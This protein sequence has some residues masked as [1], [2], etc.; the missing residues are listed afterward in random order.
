MNSRDTIKL[1]TIALCVGTAFHANAALYNVFEKQSPEGNDDKTY[2]VAISKSPAESQSCW[3]SACD[4][5]S[6]YFGLEVKRHE[7]GFSYRSEVPFDIGN[8]FDY[9]ADGHNGFEDYCEDYLGYTDGNCNDFFA[10]QQYDK[11][12][13]NEVDG[14]Y[15]NSIAYLFKEDGSNE[16]VPNEQPLNAVINQIS[17]DGK[18]TGSQRTETTR[19]VGFSS[20]IFLPTGDDERTQAFA[21]LVHGDKTYISGSISYKKNY[22]YWYSKATFWQLDSKGEVIDLV[23]SFDWNGGK[24]LDD[25][26]TSNGSIRDLVAIGDAVYGVGYNSND[27]EEPVATVFSNLQKGKE[28]ISIPLP[29]QK[30]YQNSIL[31]TVNENGLAVGTAKYRPKNGGSGFGRAYPNRLFY[32]EKING[33]ALNYHYVKD[34]DERVLFDGANTK[35]GAINNF[36]ELVGAVDFEKHAEIDGKPRAQRAFITTLLPSE[37]GRYENI[38]RSKSWFLDDLTN[39]SNSETENNQYRVINATDINDQGIISAT[40]MKCEGGYQSTAHDSL[41]DKTEQIVAVQ[42]VPIKGASQTDITERTIEDNY[43]ERKG[44]GLGWLALT[45]LCL[46]GFRRK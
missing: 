13:K 21:R 18:V 8:G 5:N 35:V 36:N 33:S 40:A 23:H 15:N 20:D 12:Y 4:E 32:V 45:M 43:S 39:G 27:D 37:N 25:K 2:G 9:L 7:E 6:S 16:L 42:L 1:T 22:K 14:N 41:C 28:A 3:T 30:N 26:R 19:N 34:N 10:V 24:D 44:A 11:G 17:A 31:H 38:Y 46:F 29:D